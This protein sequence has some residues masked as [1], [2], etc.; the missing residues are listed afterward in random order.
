[1]DGT[2]GEEQ[3]QASA[4]PILLPY[5]AICQTVFARRDASTTSEDTDAVTKSLP[6]GGLTRQDSIRNQRVVQPLQ[7]AVEATD[8]T[9][10]PVPRST[11][12]HPMEPGGWRIKGLLPPAFARLELISSVHLM[13]HSRC[14]KLLRLS[15]VHAQLSN[16]RQTRTIPGMSHHESNLQILHINFQPCQGR[17]VSE[18]PT[19]VPLIAEGT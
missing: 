15:F 9:L 14:Q 6:R 10:Q 2:R 1:M 7:N 8:L 3:I 12:D 17:K 19:Q 11:S 4:P 5:M 16:P 18:F 13:N